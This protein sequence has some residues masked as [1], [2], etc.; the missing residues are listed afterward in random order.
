MSKNTYLAGQPMLCQLLS[1]LH[2]DLVA[3]YQSDR[4]Y[5][6]MTTSKQFVFLFYGIIMPCKALN[7]L[8][9]HSL[10]LE[11]KLSYLGITSFPAVSTLSDVNI[12]RSSEVFARLY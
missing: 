12:N 5:K 1:C 2:R 4:Y 10:M 7:N 9:K 11:D 6:T 8:C 3:E